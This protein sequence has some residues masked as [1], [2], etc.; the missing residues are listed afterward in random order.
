L[1]HAGKEIEVFFN[2]QIVVERKFLRH[3]AYALTD[4]TRAQGA[5]FTREFALAAR[6]LDQPAQH[7]D[8]GRLTS[9]IRAEQTVNFAILDFEIDFFDCFKASE[10]L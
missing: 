5:R 3:V 7:F 10:S 9:T 2:R 6:R 8:R 1:I 4:R